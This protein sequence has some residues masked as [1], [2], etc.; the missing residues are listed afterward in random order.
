MNSIGE[1][2]REVERL[3]A[4]MDQLHAVTEQN[5]VLE[6]QVFKALEARMVARRQRRAEVIAAV[7]KL[8][9]FLD[10]LPDMIA[11]QAVVANRER[12]GRDGRAG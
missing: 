8:S 12:S 1:V 3:R 4:S 6:E 2:L 9:Q 7:Q 5:R 11:S 10:A